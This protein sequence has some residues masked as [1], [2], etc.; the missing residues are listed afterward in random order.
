M[1]I[2]SLLNNKKIKII[3]LLIL[4]LIGCILFLKLL[5]DKDIVSVYHQTKWSEYNPEIERSIKK[6]KYSEK[7]NLRTVYGGIASHHIP[8]TIPNLVNF[9]SDLKNNQSVRKIIII[10]PDHNDA[11][12]S[13]ISASNVSFFTSYG[14]VKPIENLSIEL[15]KSGLVSIEESPFDFEHSIGS[16]ILVIS[17][18]FPGVQV[19]P[20]IFRSDIPK[21]QAKAL[22]EKL[23]S[24]MDEETVLIASVDFSHYLSTNQSAPIDNKSADVIRNLDLESIH[25]IEADSNETLETFMIVMNNKKA[26]DND[27]VEVLNTNDL[28]QNFDYT[29]GYVFGFWGIK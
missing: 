20:I 4:L 5:P 11:G 26:F 23:A 3:T 16:Q 21:G 22:G 13:S 6:Y 29:T 8:T 28:M 15:E 2:R 17:K 27:K 24:L 7:I 12:K 9:Y 18:I 19:T 14:E 1:K 10:G 25:L